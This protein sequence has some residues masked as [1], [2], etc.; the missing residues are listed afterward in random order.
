MIAQTYR[1]QTKKI[2]PLSNH[3]EIGTGAWLSPTVHFEERLNLNDFLV[4]HP[5]S[6]F[7]SQVTGDGEQALGLS[8]G[9]ILVVDR[10]MAPKHN[11]LVIADVRGEFRVCRILKHGNS[12]SLEKGDGEVISISYESDF[13]SPVWGRVTHIIHSV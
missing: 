8:N 11:S 4:K 9:D 2:S 1:P 10:S 13:K 12:W 3:R 5:V 7:F 6:T